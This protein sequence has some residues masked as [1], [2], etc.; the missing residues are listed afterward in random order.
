MS[1]GQV[2]LDTSYFRTCFIDKE[3]QLPDGVGMNTE[4]SYRPLA[5]DK[6]F[7]FFEMRSAAVDTRGIDVK[8]FDFPR[9]VRE[10]K[11]RVRKQFDALRKHKIKNVVLSA[12][13][14]G[15][16][17]GRQFEEHPGLD[18]GFSLGQEMSA[19][20][21]QIYCDQIDS[22]GD[23]FDNI[24]FAIYSAG[25]GMDNFSIWD[26][27]FK[28]S[29]S[30]LDRLRSCGKSAEENVRI[31]DLETLAVYPMKHYQQKAFTE[32]A[33]TSGS[34]D[35]QE[36]SNIVELK[37]RLYWKSIKFDLLSMRFIQR[38]QTEK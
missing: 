31:Q 34:T 3:N 33:A 6:V 28:Q 22:V 18:P 11:M 30:N 29:E 38:F 21:A 37:N 20:V 36:T 24:V 10:M 13:G 16:F 27:V 35:R 9:Y 1:Q 8:E 12:F 15:A 32:W 7:P 23:E 19:A 17:I 2:I 14:C 25:Y 4:T 26:S 5:E